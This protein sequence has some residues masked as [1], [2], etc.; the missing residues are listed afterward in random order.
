ML[1]SIKE[2]Y[3]FSKVRNYGIF[4]WLLMTMA[5]SWEWYVV[6][7]LFAVCQSYP[8]VIR[9]YVRDFYKI[10]K[11]YFPLAFTFTFSLFSLIFEIL[12]SKWS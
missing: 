7:F 3:A 6:I 4:L 12:M 2:I 9:F 5:L 1:F 8:Y 11:S 10:T